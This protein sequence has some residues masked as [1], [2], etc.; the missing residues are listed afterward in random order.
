MEID[1]T[2]IVTDEQ[3]NQRIDQLLSQLLPNYSRSKI[4]QWVLDG[5]V[6]LNHAPTQNKRKVST[7]DI[8]EIQVASSPVSDTLAQAI[9]LDIVHEDESLLIIHKPAGMVVHPG[10]GNPDGTLVNALC[11]H[12]PTLS[13]LPRAGLIHRLDKD[14]S[15]LLIVAKTLAC[16]THLV[17]AMQERL[18][19]RHYQCIVNGVMIAGGTVESKIERHP[20]QRTKMAV[21]DHGKEAVTHYTIRQKFRAHTHLDVKLD[22]GRTHQIRVHM[23]HLHHPILGDLSY[24]G[25][26]HFPPACSPELKAML[27]TFKR[28]ALHAYQIAMRHP[29]TGERCQWRV[30]LPADMQTLRDALEQD[31]HDHADGFL[32]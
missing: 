23:Q 26:P 13:H 31:S 8:I 21:S 9:P 29:T 4:K 14:T 19:E 1:Q 27:E 22:T 11:H 15:G 32:S 30:D 20:R 16:H 28:Q 17:Q 2:I 12:D 3:A 25:R 10:A 18:I 6:Q 24:G 7:G 5:Q